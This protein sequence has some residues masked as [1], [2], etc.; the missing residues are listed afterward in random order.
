MISGA[1]LVISSKNPE[2]DHAFL[3]DVVKLPHVSDGGYVI[4]GLPASELSVHK[5]DRND[6]HELFLMC[7]DVKA[8]IPR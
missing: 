6:K 2:R 8:F 7:E 5:A 1:H 3:R 4:F